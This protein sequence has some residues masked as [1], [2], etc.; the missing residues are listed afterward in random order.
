MKVVAG[1]LVV[2]VGILVWALYSLKEVRQT[3]AAQQQS[4]EV[5][6]LDFSNRWET[7]RRS[8]DEQKRVNEVLETNLTDRARSLESSK[9]EI[10]GLTTDL[11]KSRAETK[12]AQD[13]VAKRDAQ[14]ST[15]E[16]R[17][18]DLTKQM[19]DLQTAITGLES[20]ITEAERKLAT[21][22]G[23]RQDL[24][25]ELQHLQNEKIAMEK[26]LND[27]AFVRDQVRK[28]KDELTVARRLEWI[29]RGI[30]TS[31]SR[32][33]AEALTSS[34]TAP[35][36]PAKTDAAGGGLEVELKTSGEVKVS[37][38]TNASNATPK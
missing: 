36:E 8:L 14:I 9:V 10:A 18:G 23:N 22:E 16:N 11:A 33:G 13:E 5:I 26:Q 12:T 34:K 25:K 20:Q 1:I 2:V 31:G 6:I 30:Y 27:L 32:K 19:G 38:S 7:T 3:M 29:R 15:L 24:L 37:T 35:K 21:S 4:N 17:N 28:L